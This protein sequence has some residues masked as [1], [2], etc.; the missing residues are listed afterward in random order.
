MYS[1]YFSVYSLVY[2]NSVPCTVT[3]DSAGGSA[4]SSVSL[5]GG[6]TVT[7]PA[8]PVRDNYTFEGWLLGGGT[9]N[10]TTPI[11]CDITLTAEWKAVKT[12]TT[13]TGST[14]TGTS[15]SRTSGSVGASR[16]RT[17][18]GTTKST[19]TS[20]SGSSYSGS[21]SSMSSLFSGS[22]SYNKSS[23]AYSNPWAELETYEENESETV[24]YEPEMTEEEAE[25]EAILE[26][27]DVIEATTEKEDPAEKEEERAERLNIMLLA[28]AAI[29]G[30]LFVSVIV[31]LLYE[32]KQLVKELAMRNRKSRAV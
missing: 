1:R 7:K 27:E 19:T 16:S 18:T 9:F 22:S 13:G 17:T 8:D 10:F 12:T 4:V 25:I 29:A 23:N 21:S 20:R 5:K 11:T 26:S 28:G 30:I 32:M 14:G 31:W 2:A 3:F 24:M 6:N 15:R